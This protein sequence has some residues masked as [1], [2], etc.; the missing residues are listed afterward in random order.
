MVSLH[1]IP[2]VPAALAA[3]FG[4]PLRHTSI[5]QIPPQCNDCK[6]SCVNRTLNARAVA[7]SCFVCLC[8]CFCCLHDKISMSMSRAQIASFSAGATVRCHCLGMSGAPIH[9]WLRLLLLSD[10]VRMPTQALTLTVPRRVLT[11]GVVLRSF[12]EK[13]VHR[14][15]FTRNTTWRV[16][17]SLALVLLDLSLL[18]YVRGASRG[19]A[20]NAGG[21]L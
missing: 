19:M 12:V 18:S 14:D 7:V 1:A 20:W 11:S 3:R 21:S 9:T 4:Q 16:A 2:S 10:P 8:C 13:D 5:P 17:A 6:P 15:W